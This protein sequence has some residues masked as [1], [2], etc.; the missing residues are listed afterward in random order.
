MAVGILYS[1]NSLSSGAPEA[2]VY[3]AEGDSILEND[4][5]AAIAKFSQAYSLYLEVDS[6][7][8][9]AECLLAQ[10]HC[11]FMVGE[12]E[13][14]ELLLD[15]T[16]SLIESKGIVAASPLLLFHNLAGNLAWQKGV[17]PQ[18]L[19]HFLKEIKWRKK[20]ENSPYELA[21]AF[22][23]AGFMYHLMGD[24]AN[25][26]SYFEQCLKIYR[27]EKED[28]DVISTGIL[29]SGSLLK[30]Q[31]YPAALHILEECDSLLNGLKELGQ[32]RKEDYLR[33]QGDIYEQLGLVYAAQG[34]HAQAVSMIQ[35]AIH[36]N[37]ADK[38]A[39]LNLGYV[40]LKKGAYAKARSS[41][42]HSR[43]LYE[44]KY[45]KIHP[46]IAKIDRHLG[47]IYL[48][49]NQPDSAISAF[50]QALNI[51]SGGRFDEK[52]IL[53]PQPGRFNNKREVLLLI[54]SMAKAWEQKKEL[55]HIAS[56]HHLAT[57]LIP[58]LQKEFLAEGSKTFLLETY[59]P[60]FEE[61]INSQFLLHQKDPAAVIS[62]PP[63]AF[64]YAEL[65]KSA[66]LRE[67]ME[68]HQAIQVT[69]I[70]ASLIQRETSLKNHRIYL[71]QE[72]FQARQQEDST[73]L[74]ELE[75]QVFELQVES[76]QLMDTLISDYPQLYR[77]RQEEQV[78]S[79]PDLQ[80]LMEAEEA[81]IE[82]FEGTDHVF[83]VF[84]FTS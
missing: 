65:T 30:T 16:Q 24:F 1:Q 79:I 25:A 7:D 22:N 20:A 5:F 57:L 42:L 76:D 82:F 48:E 71:E 9:A 64:Q 39:W 43:A 61:A 34:N 6:V 28:L 47:E 23:N 32:I 50:K 17:F 83:G 33:D 14:V 10:V 12:L 73:Y 3:M 27:E 67:S 19:D 59:L 18:G 60:I 36:L 38:L 58:Q 41:F 31:K 4:P 75:Q 62:I 54:R 63:L 51:Y 37:E 2:A 21:T 81:I 66:L 8:K 15:S 13:K 29:M 55:A 69:D 56:T 52:M 70:P 40:L 53:T 78:V 72:L 84:N 46:R 45:G 49:E 77:Q 11:N 44:S 74:A 26:L 80:A 35:K 68:L